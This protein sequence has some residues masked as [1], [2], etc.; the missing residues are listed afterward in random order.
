MYKIDLK[1]INPI[2]Q[3]TLQQ[4][5]NI[6]EQE[7][8]NAL[9]KEEAEYNKETTLLQSIYNNELNTDVILSKQ[10]QD[11]KTNL[12]TLD[13]TA[14][15]L[16]T[17]NRQLEISMDETLKRNNILFFL[18]TIFVC[19]LLSFIPVLLLKNNKI[20]T[21]WAYIMLGVIGCVL[22]MVSLR[23]LFI[24]S[25]KDFVTPT[26]KTVLNKKT[27]HA[28]LQQM[29]SQTPGSIQSLVLTIQNLKT[30]AI[31]SNDFITASM[32]QNMLTNIEQE[33]ALG[34]PLGGYSSKAQIQNMIQQ[35]KNEMALQNKTHQAQNIA[36]ISQLT[37]A[38]M[39]KKALLGT[40]QGNVKTVL[41]KNTSVQDEISKTE[42][43]IKSMETELTKL[44]H[45]K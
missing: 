23:H 38:I 6:I 39:E 43:N 42:S 28:H 11:I 3:Q 30:T 27:G 35:I 34:N 33:L 31:K 40:L 8:Q 36:R 13:N 26:V 2:Y 32:C 16:M 12:N 10:D 14:N 21:K 22:F 24:M 9:Q 19:L 37:T 18:K 44:K 25:R 5:L 17:I 7:K 29:Y 15:N 4:K 20:D 45:S 1:N 41:T